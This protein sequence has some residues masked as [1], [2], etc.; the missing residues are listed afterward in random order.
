MMFPYP[1]RKIFSPA[2]MLSNMLHSQHDTKSKNHRETNYRR[3]ITPKDQFPCEGSDSPALSSPAALGSWPT[4]SITPC[5]TA[6]H[7]MALHSTAQHGAAQHGMTRCSTAW[8]GMAEKS[9]E[10]NTAAQH[11]MTQHGAAWH[12]VAQCRTMQH[13]TAW[14]SMV[15]YSMA[16]YGMA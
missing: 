8:H 1:S 4:G 13:G 7:G 2:G 12:G 16:W 9:S 11:S 15:W 14:C 5:C 6:R 3:K 10:W